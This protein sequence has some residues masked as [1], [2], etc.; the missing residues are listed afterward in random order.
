ME[1]ITATFLLR[2][3]GPYRVIKSTAQMVTIE[4]DGLQHIVSA[5]CFSRAPRPPT[6][7]HSQDTSPPPAANTATSLRSVGI[8]GLL[9]PAPLPPKV[10][11]PHATRI[12]SSHPGSV[13]PPARTV[14]AD[15][16]GP[17]VSVND[18]YDIYLPDEDQ[19]WN[20]PVVSPR[21]DGYDTCRP[22]HDDHREY[23]VNCIV[24]AGLGDHGE[25]L[26]KVLWF[27]YGPEKDKLEPRE[28]IPSN[29]IK[30]YWSTIG[31]TE[32]ELKEGR[33]PGHF[34]SARSP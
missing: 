27:G 18:G 19:Q 10:R 9:P 4:H 16:H 14:L 3:S 21:T 32:R 6:A 25:V 28:I 1:D 33:I 7:D 2:F 20:K 15:P 31:Q 17:P 23:V 29:F 30:R 22:E 5:D 24:S 26:H 8:P 12:P 11:P 34:F 13:T